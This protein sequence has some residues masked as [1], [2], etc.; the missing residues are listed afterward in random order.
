MIGSGH[1][2]ST[3]NEALARPNGELRTLSRLNL[4]RGSRP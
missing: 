4:L 3:F 2:T 1:N